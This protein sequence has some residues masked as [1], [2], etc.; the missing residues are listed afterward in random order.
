MSDD[1]KRD[2]LEDRARASVDSPREPAAPSSPPRRR[3]LVVEDNADARETLRLLLELSGHEV[4]LA[5]NGRTGVAL[6]LRTR[7]EVALID[8]GLP[9]LD[10]WELAR[11]VR[12][13]P[14]GTG[15]RLVA[16]TGYGQ[17]HDRRRAGEAG[18]DAY[19]VKPIDRESL[20][21]ALQMS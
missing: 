2:P 6:A 10:G 21:A 16:L 13:A 20:D 14:E 3:I 9:D 1:V 11:R 5:A 18:F 17:P 12:A 15:I 7:P 8:L 19:L 4:H